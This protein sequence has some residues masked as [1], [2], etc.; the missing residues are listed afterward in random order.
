MPDS[1]ILAQA[2]LYLPKYLTPAQKQELYAELERFPNITSFY[3]APGTIDEDLLQGDG[4]HGFVVINFDNLERKVVGGLLLSNSCDVDARNPR[5]LPTKVL[6]SPLVSL[7]RYEA[8]LRD[9]GVEESRLADML[10]SIRGQNVSHIFYLPEAPYGPRESMV[11]LDNIQSQPLDVFLRSDRNLLF[12][13]NQTGHYVLL[14]KLS[15]HFSR[16]LEDTQRFPLGS[17]QAP[18]NRPP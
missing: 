8:L 7:A 3:L 12:R 1:D 17:A 4:W 6:F 10:R 13:L 14:I 5:A 9:A 16:F 15:I 11:L 2:S 18:S